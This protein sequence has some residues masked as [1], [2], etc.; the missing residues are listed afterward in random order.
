MPLLAWIYAAI[1]VS[2]AHAAPLAVQW[3]DLDAVV[4]SEGL[5]YEEQLL[6]YVFQGLANRAAVAAPQLMLNGAYINFDWPGA[7]AYWRAYLTSESRVEF[8]NITASL[9]GLLAEGDPAHLIKGTVAYDPTLAAGNASE[10]ALPI[11]VTVAAQQHLLP[12]TDALLARFPCVAVLPI[13]TDLRTAPWASN[14]SAAW[15]WAFAN[16]L[17]QASQTVAFNLYHYMPGASSARSR[18]GVRMSWSPARLAC[19]TFDVCRDHD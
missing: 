11:A 7:D 3:F 15:E 13:V 16:L 10:W 8:T 14:E 6:V 12:V 17:P 19:C 18:V 9:C 1:V 2:V 5:S 4:A